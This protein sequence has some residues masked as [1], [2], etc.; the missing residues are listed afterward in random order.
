MRCTS[1]SMA[2]ASGS[3]ETLR[4]ISVS[5]NC[6]SISCSSAAVCG[7]RLPVSST[8]PRPSAAFTSVSNSDSVPT[9]AMT[10]SR[11]VCPGTGTPR[12]ATS[13]TVQ[14]MCRIMRPSDPLKR[15]AQRDMEHVSALT[16]PSR[17]DAPIRVEAD[18]STH[19]TDDTRVVV[20]PATQSRTKTAEVDVGGSLEDIAEVCESHAGDIAE[21]RHA[22]LSID[23]DLRVATGGKPTRR[24]RVELTELVHRETAMGG[25][26]AGKE[27]FA[28]RQILERLHSVRQHLVHSGIVGNDRNLGVEAVG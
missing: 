7:S 10:R 28:G 25:R 4:R 15:F 9:R 16:T 21:Q 24:K 3:G 5:I 6:R 22:Q 12:S 20:E 14:T 1:S 2:A 11:R 19:H 18:L 27:A 23:K 26:A 8:M 13:T 17:Q